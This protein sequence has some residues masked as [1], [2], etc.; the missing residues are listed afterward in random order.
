MLL[1]FGVCSFNSRMLH[2]QSVPTRLST[3]P[4]LTRDPTPPLP[5]LTGACRHQVENQLQV[6]QG[7][8]CLLSQKSARILSRNLTKATASCWMHTTSLSSFKAFRAAPTLVSSSKLF[9]TPCFVDFLLQ[10]GWT[11]KI[12]S[13]SRLQITQIGDP[14]EKLPVLPVRVYRSSSVSF[15]RQGKHG[16]DCSTAASDSWIKHMMYIRGSQDNLMFVKDQ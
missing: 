1:S 12:Q 2:L 16:A 9:C 15:N 3:M 6:S 11:C 13:L 10:H 8:K 5:H 7:H 14:S 4:Q